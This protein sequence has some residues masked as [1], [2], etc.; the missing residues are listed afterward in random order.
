MT[1]KSESFFYDSSKLLHN[2][3]NEENISQSKIGGRQHYL[4][5][6]VSRTPMLWDSAQYDYDSTLSYADKVGFR[7]GICYEY[8]MY[9]L[10]NRKSLKLKQR[11]LVVMDVSVVSNEYEGLGYTDEA[12]SRCL[13]FKNIVKI[14]SGDF[15][16]LW[17]NTSF[18]GEKSK[19]IY[20]ELI[21]R[22]MV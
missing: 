9:D 21:S 3:L 8:T 20:R 14:Y 7:C 1:Y 4:R 11:P 17:H 18:I 22:E 2:I 15:V 13:Y 19:S 5:W 10:V 6:D 16:L 12:L